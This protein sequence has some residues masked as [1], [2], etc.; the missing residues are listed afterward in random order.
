[1]LPELVVLKAA[2]RMEQ[3][4]VLL[5]DGSKSP[6]CSGL[7]QE[8]LGF[9][10]LVSLLAAPVGWIPAGGLGQPCRRPLWAESK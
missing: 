2:E 1:M 3:H 7:T 9:L 8:Q 10:F 5:L 6:Q 4:L